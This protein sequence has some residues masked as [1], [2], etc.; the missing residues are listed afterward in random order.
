MSAAVLDFSNVPWIVGAGIE[1]SALPVR[2]DRR[3]VDKGPHMAELVHKR[4]EDTLDYF[5]DLSR[6]LEPHEVIVVARARTLPADLQVLRVD[7]APQG[8]VVW[9]SQGADGVRHEVQ[10]QVQTSLGKV[11]L[12]RFFAI[13][14][15]NGVPPLPP[16][17]TITVP[18]LEIVLAPTSPGLE[19]SATTID[20]GTT[21]LS[22]GEGIVT[23]KNTGTAPLI[24]TSI[25]TTGP[26]SV[27][28]TS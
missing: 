17:I 10:A 28:S 7:F 2:K 13:T 26:F 6:W 4:G 9:L 23:I 3:I 27:V 19:V 16:P 22:G 25:T 15:G 1:A 5:I 11:K 12:I 20:F 8:A 14:R 21:D 18:D 24:I